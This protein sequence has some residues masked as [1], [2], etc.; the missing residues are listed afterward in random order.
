[1][2]AKNSSRKTE[3]KAPMI[4]QLTLDFGP[5]LV[6]IPPKTIAMTTLRPTWHKTVAEPNLDPLLV[7]AKRKP[8]MPNPIPEI[9]K[10][11]RP[12]FIKSIPLNLAAFLLE[13]MNLFLL[14][15]LV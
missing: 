8:Q 13:P 6:V 1:M 12:A 11:I 2:A 14:P 3:K 4:A 5:P 9:A 15:T 7:Q 10:E